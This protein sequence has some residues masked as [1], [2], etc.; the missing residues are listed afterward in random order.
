MGFNKFCKI[1]PM[2]SQH[3]PNSNSPPPV[4]FALH[5]PLGT[6]IG[7]EPMVGLLCPYVWTSVGR[8]SNAADP[9]LYPVLGPVLTMRID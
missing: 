8:F 1:F 7:E 3:V 4:F 6:Y 9:V 2:C 5:Y